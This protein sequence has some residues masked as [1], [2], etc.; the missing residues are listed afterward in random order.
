MERQECRKDL[1]IEKKFTGDI[2]GGCA[3]NDAPNE[4]EET[5]SGGHKGGENVLS[6]GGGAAHQEVDKRQVDGEGAAFTKGETGVGVSADTLNEIAAKVQRYVD[7]TVLG[8]GSGADA[9][10]SS[11]DSDYEAE[12]SLG[13]S[14]VHPQLE[15]QVSSSTHSD[16]SRTTSDTLAAEFAEYVTVQGPSPTQTPGYT[17]RVEFALKLGYTERL[18]QAALHKLGPDPGQN[19]LLAELIKLGATCSSKLAD[20]PD[21]ADALMESTDLSGD[22]CGHPTGNLT[23]SSA[24]RPVVIDGSNV[25]MSHGNKEIFSCRG[26]K[27]CVDW[28][29][30]RGHREIT[31]FVPKWRKEASRPDNPITEQEILGE[32]ERDRLLVFTPS[33]LVGGKRMVCYDDR[34]ILRLA[35][36]LD[37]IVV[38]NDNYRDLAQ[39]SPEFRKVIEERILMYSFVND[40]FMPPDDPLGRSGPTLD[41]FLRVGARR[42]DPAPPCPYAKKCTYGNKCKFRHPERG[43]HPQKS[44]TERLVEHAQRHLQARGPSLSLPLPAVT[45][46]SVTVPQHQP[47]CKTRSA[48]VQSSSSVPKS[49]SV[50]NVTSDLAYS[51]VPPGQTV[52]GYPSAVGW[53]QRVSNSEPEPVNMHRKLQRQLTLNPVCDPRLYQ[54][55]RYHQQ[56]SMPSAASSQQAPQQP[57]VINAPHPALHRPLTRHTSND[58]PY[59]VPI[60]WDHQEHHHHLHQHVT[61]I[62][63]APDSYRAWPPCGSLA[64][65]SPQVP[66]LGAS[67]PQ[68]NLLPSASPWGATQTQDARRRLHYHLASIFPEEQVQA[69]MA[70][71]PHETDA[72]QICAAILAMFPKS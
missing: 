60:N 22:D 64:A 45:S 52:Q 30:A 28:F 41:N 25:A 44:V 12:D 58:S 16:V 5:I 50:E 40:R 24:F 57:P 11:Y 39:E 68:L 65:P 42:T 66:R 17:A 51:K 9:E 4:N 23:G 37:G 47:L 46:S 36:E 54:L 1:R 2:K 19:E 29:R 15:S 56:K 35:A 61:R 20:S 70:L 21:E 55:R 13:S 26:I 27:I 49:R 62:A 59:P 18:V 43:P 69:A 31:V 67:D 32:L 6:G 3:L 48:I 38:S 10:D 72:Q 71:H 8:S 33:R 53:T 63:S 7:C 14:S 34:Y